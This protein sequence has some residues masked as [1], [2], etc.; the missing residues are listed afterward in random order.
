[1]NFFTSRNERDESGPFW[2]AGMNFNVGS[3]NQFTIRI[4]YE[5]YDTDGFDDI[6][7][8]SGGFIYN[9]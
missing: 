6:R 4:D 3:R 9:F 8:V 1:M 7:S 2:G 5:Q